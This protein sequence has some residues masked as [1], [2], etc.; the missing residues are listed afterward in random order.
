L[1]KKR[2]S[3]NY[4][5]LAQESGGPTVTTGKDLKIIIQETCLLFAV[6]S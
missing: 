4:E 5:E 6:K 2:W 3:V 1:F